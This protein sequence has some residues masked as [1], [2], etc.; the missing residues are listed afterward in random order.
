MTGEH[1][2]RILALWGVKI[3]DLAEKLGESQPNTSAYFNVKDFKTG[4]LTRI[5]EATGIPIYEFFGHDAVQINSGENSTQIQNGS[6][7]ISIINQAGVINRVFAEIT[8]TRKA[9]AEAMLESQK[10][11]ARLLSIIENM[12]K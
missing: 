11:N 7:D 2:K 3:T 8:E 12:Q 4:T 5:S 6:G 1:V 9:L 10:L